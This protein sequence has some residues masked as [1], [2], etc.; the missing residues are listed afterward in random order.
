[1]Y[2]CMYIYIYLYISHKT[3]GLFQAPLLPA[4]TAIPLRTI[5]SDTHSD[6]SLSAFGAY[7][8]HTGRLSQTK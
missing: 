3:Q 8:V 6:L 4:C 1:M 5:A 7:T 2:I